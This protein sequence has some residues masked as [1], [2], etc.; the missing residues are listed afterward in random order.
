[1]RPIIVLLVQVFVAFLLVGAVMPI[2]LVS[3]PSARAP[4]VG[5]PIVLGALVLGLIAVRWLWP[6]TKT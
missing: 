3:V 2:V 1:M 4:S 5:M 6:R